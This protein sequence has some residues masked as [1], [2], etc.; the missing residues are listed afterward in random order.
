MKNIQVRLIIAFG[1]IVLLLLLQGIIAYQNIRSIANIQKKAYTSRLE[2]QNHENRLANTRLLVFKILGTRNPG[3]MD[4]LFEQFQKERDSL[5]QDLLDVGIDPDIIRAN[6]QSYDRAIALHYDF[7]FRTAE[8]VLKEQSKSRHAALVERLEAVSRTVQQVSE[9]EIQEAYQRTILF[10]FGLLILGLLIAL[11]LA[12]VLAR[13]LMDRQQ[14]EKQLKKSEEKYRLLVDTANDAIFIA[15]DDVIKFPNP[16]A[17]A[18]TG[19]SE[20]ELLKTPFVN[21]I[22]PED[23]AMVLERYRQRI[24]GEGPPASYAFR[25]VNKDDEIIWVQ[26]NAALTT[27]EDKP[28][29]INLI[30]DITRQK[31]LENQLRQSQKME[32][33]GTLAGGIAH[34]FNNIL[35]PLLG[36]AEML[37]EDIPADSPLQNSL[38]EILKATFRARDLVKQ[39]LA[40]SRQ[41]EQEVKPLSL[42]PIIKEALKLLRSSIPST[43]DIRQDID[44][45]CGVVLADPTQIHQI[46]MNLAT[47]A[48][49]A[50]EH[51]GGRLH[52]ELEQ[53]HLE[54]GRTAL[55]GLPWGDYARLSIADTGTGIDKDTLDKIFDPYFTT[56]ET[57]K[58]TGLGLSVVQG[59]VVRN[60]GDIQVLSEPGQGTRVLIYLPVVG[61]QAAAEPGEQGRPIRGGSERILLIDDEPSILKMEQQMLERLG[62]TVTVRTGSLEALETFRSDPE[63]FDLVVTDMTMPNMTGIQLAAELKMLRPELPIV[64]CTGFNNLVN[65]EKC[66]A[67]GIQGF[68]MKPVIMKE[69]ASTIREVL[70]NGRPGA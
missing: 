6:F 5:Q 17:L 57:G 56:K 22:H 1:F 21:I 49:Q 33:I 48:Y 40:F 41:G 29:T 4:A 30:R 26:I 12:F 59:I 58:G 15:Q 36:F 27:W 37:K 64:L 45:E 54:Q 60:H 51:T 25:I 44:P 38:D 43:I 19:Y 68:V 10:T 42:Q 65:D 32:S 24:Q 7:R 13:T 50:M 62:Y 52:V 18:M 8:Q 3:Q 53:V 14:A 11:V 39:I 61:N 63:A 31:Q 55:P 23:R 46:I 34:D 66:R 69:L 35:Y 2:I 20:E 28:A 9:Q 70:D 47:N 16:K 67:N